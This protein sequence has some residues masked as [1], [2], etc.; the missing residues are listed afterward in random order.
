MN[1]IL[2]A[3]FLAVLIHALL[4]TADK[5]RLIHSVSPV[6]R[7]EVIAMQLVERVKPSPPVARPPVKPLPKPEKKKVKKRKLIKRK[8][9]KI[10]PLKK[11]PTPTPPKVS[12]SIVKENTA[13]SDTPPVKANEN[14]P[15]SSVKSNETVK[16][17][18]FSAPAVVMAM[19]RYSENSPPAYP[20]MARKRGYEG[21]VILEVFVKTDGRVGDLRVFES[22]RHKLLD[23]AAVKA[24]KEWLFEPGRKGEETVA[25]WVRVPLDF[26]LQ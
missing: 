8:T 2:P 12:Q 14:P 4:L 1:R 3:F 25:M 5:N 20:P 9:A 22:S 16:V 10:K 24:V 21:R 11:I 19:P 26:R 13:L 18:S 15:A 23:H 17:A 7:E 6:H